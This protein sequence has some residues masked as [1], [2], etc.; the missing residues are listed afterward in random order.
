[1]G[2]N[3][4]S[5]K[6]K[7][8]HWEV[9]SVLLMFYDFLAVAASYFAAL[10]LRFDCQLSK[11]DARYLLAYS[12][13]ILIYAGFCVVVFWFMRLYKSIWRFASYAELLRMI[14]ATVFSMVYS[15]AP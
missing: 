4:K 3:A 11:I 2:E 9:I 6:K 15:S 5:N 1:M 8:E 7:I 14:L 13:S 12:D 10:W